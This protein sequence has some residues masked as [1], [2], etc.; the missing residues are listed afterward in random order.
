MLDAE[1]RGV[2]RGA[3]AAAVVAAS[4]IG[5]GVAFWPF[6]YPRIDA[7]ADRLRYAIRCD[8]FVAAWLV[9]MIAAIAT[10][11]FGSPA[12]IGGSGLS[13]ATPPVRR[14]RAVLENTLE[15]I[16]LAMPLHLGLA[17]LL[18]LRCIVVV[19]I[20]AALFG[21]GRACFWAG[22]A[23]GAAA[24]AFGFG[25][26]FYPAVAGYLVAAALIVQGR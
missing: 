19:P 1:Q 25:L 14:A 7:I 23:R 22:Y 16:V 10:L 21:L 2:A 26:T 20:L 11:R 15:Q 4:A 17:L 8:L 5:L 3:A 9:P 6:A 24:R 12:D 13:E 18:P